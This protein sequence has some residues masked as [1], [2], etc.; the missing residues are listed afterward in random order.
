MN[1]GKLHILYLEDQPDDAF[2]VE[3]VLRKGGYVPTMVLVDSR[4]NFVEAIRNNRFDVIL[5]D[6][7]LP[8]FNSTEAIKICKRAQVIVPI[9]LVTGTVSEE[10]AA[11]CIK[12]GADDYIL[13]SNLSRLP[14]AIENA[15]HQRSLQAEKLTAE[16][17]LRLKN[18]ELTKINQELDSFVYSVSHNLRAPL[19]SLLGLLNLANKDNHARDPV[20]EHYFKMMEDSIKKLDITLKEIIEY[21]RNA[22]MEAI[23]T[24]IN[25][26][27]IIQETLQKIQYLEGIDKIRIDIE[28][29]GKENKFHCD[30]HRLSV[31]ITSLL[32][33]AIQYRDTTNDNAHIIIH[34]DISNEKGATL[35][36][37]DNGIGI[38]S[39][40]LE[41]IFKMFYRATD[42]SKGAGLGLYNVKETT[43]KLGGRIRV[44]SIEGI[45]TIF[46][47]ALPQGRIQ[48]QVNVR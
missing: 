12:I 11:T 34:I 6:H 1:R 30:Q 20:Y 7:S 45:G 48:R 19:M 31:I 25:F 4:K 9:I 46:T 23:I 22:R 21:S 26:E 15:I 33:N 29:S 27:A 47:I 10:F 5:S 40:H 39:D 13:K 17:N 35:R 42:R 41:K 38:P 36:I 3:R 28:I 44:A 32:T 18:E 2:F 14:Q 43:E 8:Q 37:E 16:I 24:S